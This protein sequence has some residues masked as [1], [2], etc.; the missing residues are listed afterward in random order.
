M[1]SDN[2]GKRDAPPLWNDR[3]TIGHLDIDREHK[4]LFHIAS[5]LFEANDAGI[6]Q[7]DIGDILC[8]LAD[9]TGKHFAH[10]EF[11]MYQAKYPLCAEHVVKHW[12]FIQRLSLM[13][14]TYERAPHEV[15]QKLQSVIIEWLLQ[16]IMADDMKFGEF[17]NKHHGSD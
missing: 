6:S 5:R 17:W 4:R 1:T 14:N 11:L 3:L 13:I 7:S 8:E 15:L 10:E 12:N 2:I 9:Y 16:H